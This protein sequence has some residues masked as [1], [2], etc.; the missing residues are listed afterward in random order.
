MLDSTAKIKNLC[1]AIEA[2]HRVPD[3]GRHLHVLDD[4]LR[5]T[6][7]LEREDIAQETQRRQDYKDNYTS[8][9]DTPAF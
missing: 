1:I 3:A 7:T 4:L 2:L 5:D 8:P 6:I 9:N